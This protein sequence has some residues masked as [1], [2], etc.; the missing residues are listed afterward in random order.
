MS[1]SDDVVLDAIVRAD[2]AYIADL[3]VSGR[4]AEAD[5]YATRPDVSARIRRWKALNR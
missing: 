2:A 1:P 5:Q 3:V 4:S